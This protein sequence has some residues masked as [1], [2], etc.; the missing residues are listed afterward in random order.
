AGLERLIAAEREAQIE[1]AALRRFSAL[2]PPHP[3]VAVK[4]AARLK[5]SNKARKRLACAVER[6]LDSNP[7][8]LAYRIGTE[9]AVDRLLVAGEPARAASAIHWR[10]PSLPLG[11]GTLISRGVPEGPIVARTLRNI[12]DNWVDAGFPTGE[13]F[14][15]I[16]TD[17][18]ATASKS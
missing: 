13:A 15:R 1:P 11:G 16:V 2:L 8:A 12:E 4:M 14:E 6:Q 17:A 3:I 10:I 18:L 7:Q 5:L 9:C